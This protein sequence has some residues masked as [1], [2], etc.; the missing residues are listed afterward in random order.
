MPVFIVDRKLTKGLCLDS[1]GKGSTK[2]LDDEL[3]RDS[4]RC[5]SLYLELKDI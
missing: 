4:E 2:I 5:G 3:F 1:F